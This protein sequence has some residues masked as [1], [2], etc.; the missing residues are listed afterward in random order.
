MKTTLKILLLFSILLIS[1]KDEENPIDNSVNEDSSFSFPLAV[2][3]WWEY[4]V[5]ELAQGRP[6]I[7]SKRLEVI[8]KTYFQGKEAYKVKQTSVKRNEEIYFSVSDSNI[9][10][11]G[12][13][14]GGGNV[15]YPNWIKLYDP[16]TTDWTNFDITYQM[17]SYSKTRIISTSKYS[18]MPD[19]NF[20]GVKH[21]AISVQHKIENIQTGKVNCVGQD[22]EF[23]SEIN[24]YYV[25]VDKVGIIETST[26]Y[27]NEKTNNTKEELKEYSLIE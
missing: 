26:Y 18:T 6:N 5:F 22:Y 12:G 15:P 19:F 2:G 10:H 9:Y 11:G 8:E 14:I 17:S 20:N 4:D 21:I 7:G 23:R 3:N 25:I 27:D 16:D 24:Y 1:C 13:N